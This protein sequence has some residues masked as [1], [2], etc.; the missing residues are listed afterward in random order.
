[1]TLLAPK[2][3]YSAPSRMIATAKQASSDIEVRS[4]PR[5]GRMTV[6]WMTR[7]S[8]NMAGIVKSRPRNRSMCRCTEST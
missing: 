8:T 3:Q 5:R 2:I 1:M 6:V 4:A 7:P